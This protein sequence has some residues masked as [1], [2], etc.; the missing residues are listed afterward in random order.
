MNTHTRSS[1]ASTLNVPG[2]AV[3]HRVAL[4]GT[5]QA[6]AAAAGTQHAGGVRPEVFGD[7]GKEPQPAVK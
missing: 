5:G 4:T 6:R 2:L 3:T 1:S 7:A